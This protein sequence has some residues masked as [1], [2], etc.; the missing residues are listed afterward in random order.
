MPLLF[1]ACD[2]YLQSPKSFQESLNWMEDL[3]ICQK[4]TKYGQVMF[5]E[6]VKADMANSKGS[7]FNNTITSTLTLTTLLFE[8]LFEA[9]IIHRDFCGRMEDPQPSITLLNKTNTFDGYEFNIYIITDEV[10]AL[11]KEL[12]VLFEDYCIFGFREFYKILLCNL[13]EV[14]KTMFGNNEG[15]PDKLLNIFLL[16]SPG[17]RNHMNQQVG[18][19]DPVFPQSYRTIFNKQEFIIHNSVTQPVQY[20][21]STMPTMSTV[22]DN[23]G[24]G[25]NRI[26]TDNYFKNYFKTSEMGDVIQQQKLQHHNSLNRITIN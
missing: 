8:D 4:P 7:S 5:C 23:P 3:I 12:L 11:Q 13:V 19:T 9:I 24:A 21:L 15:V 26:N 1:T 2:N 6:A 10:N 17:V 16:S 20:S 22:Y 14:N 25:W 18:A